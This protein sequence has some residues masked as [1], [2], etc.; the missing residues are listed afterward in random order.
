MGLG[1]TWQHRVCSPRALGAAQPGHRALHTLAGGLAG[2]GR[3]IPA[4]SPSFCPSP[5]PPLALWGSGQAGEGV[6][7]PCPTLTFTR[8]SLAGRA[9]LPV[10]ARR[11]REW[12][13]AVKGSPGACW[14]QNPPFLP[15]A[16][17]GGGPWASPGSRTAWRG[18][19][20]SGRGRRSGHVG[21]LLEGK[22]RCPRPPSSPCP[23]PLRFTCP[24]PQGL[25]GPKPAPEPPGL[26]CCL[27]HPGSLALCLLLAWR[28]PV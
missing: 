10:G 7:S 20:E 3:S 23:G 8:R 15:L 22:G 24:R 19:R 26:C 5:A 2:R 16:S 25:V 17:P 1:A 12:G 11:P 13:V 18:E 4:A 6:S 27:S 28:L 14:E 9:A 21:S